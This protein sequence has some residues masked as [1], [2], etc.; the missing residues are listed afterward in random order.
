MFVDRMFLEIE[1]G[2]RAKVD[3]LWKAKYTDQ[4]SFLFEGKIDVQF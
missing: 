3:S 2:Y 1:M 4:Y